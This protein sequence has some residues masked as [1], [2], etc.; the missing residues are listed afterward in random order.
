MSA[1]PPKR[2]RCLGLLALLLA[3]F[4]LACAGSG[5]S[6]ADGFSAKGEY[7][8]ESKYNLISKRMA[9]N[10]DGTINVVVEIP[11]GT[12]AK[13]AVSEDG[14]ALVRDFTG[15]T[16]RVIDYLPYPGNYGMIPRTLISEQDG[17]DGSA[18]DIMVIG[19]AVPR[20]SILRARAIG[21][22]RVID[23]LEQDDKILAVADGPTMKGVYDVESMRLRYPGSAEIIS[24]WWANA[25]GRRSKVDVLG[26]GSRG[27][28]SSIIEF[29]IESY[30]TNEQ[31][32]RKAAK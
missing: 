8:Y 16:P 27:Q 2:S 20:G 5:G 19:P 26:T 29:G 13:W 4:T 28:A 21:V 31:K 11:A 18:L 25:H 32:N 1:A 14:T 9:R 10:A 22:I 7:R 15:E 24:T 23:R 6:V 3:A 30:K 12:S 17:G